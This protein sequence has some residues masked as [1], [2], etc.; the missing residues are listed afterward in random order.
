MATNQPAKAFM[1]IHALTPMHPG[2]GQSVGSID[3]PVQRE[4]HTSWPLIP[5]STIKGILRDACRQNGCDQE[6]LFAVFGPDTNEADK[7]A[8][9]LEITDARLL[10]FPVRSL[11]GTFAWTTCAPMLERLQ[12]DQRLMGISTTSPIS[13]PENGQAI[14]VPDTSLKA[15]NSIV[16]EE[17]DFTIEEKS[18]QPADLLKWVQDNAFADQF[19]QNRFVKHLAILPED[20]FNHFARHATEVSARIRLD[21]QT[22]TVVGG[23]LFYQ[24][25]LPTETLF[26]ALL[27]A[28]DSCRPNQEDSN[29]SGAKKEP[30]LRADKALQFVRDKCGLNDSF[31]T[32]QIGGDATIGKGICAVKLL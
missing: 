23:A 10:A 12:R 26:Y 28:H 20:S 13:K 7:H 21:P 11:N 31:P 19:A 24:E 8:G 32:L 15:D 29:S 17:F 16:L 6:E 5:A 14:C 30:L 1:F 3:L 18:I 9:C 22:K 2:T 25:F 27:I 4:R